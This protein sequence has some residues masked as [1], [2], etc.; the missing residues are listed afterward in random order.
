MEDF[1]RE[2]LKIPH[3]RKK[4]KKSISSCRQQDVRF[5]IF[6]LLDLLRFLSVSALDNSI[7]L[8]GS[9]S[10]AVIHLSS[11]GHGYTFADWV[12]IFMTNATCC[13]TGIV[14]SSR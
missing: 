10:E 5:K 9:S 2:N 7:Y 6:S 8:M 12:H 3:K 1:R 4:K 14:K 13:D 11:Y